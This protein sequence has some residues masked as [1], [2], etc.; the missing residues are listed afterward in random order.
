MKYNIVTVFDETLL[1][2]STITLLNEFRDNWEK[3]IDFHCYYYNIDLAN[4]SL[5]QAP[6]IHYHNLLEVEDYKKFL[7]EYGKHDGTEGKTVPYSEN[8]DAVKYL[9]KVMAV[10]ECA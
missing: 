9:P 8:I 6:N 2:Q 4:Y 10:T 5:P 3:E 7:K 1:Q